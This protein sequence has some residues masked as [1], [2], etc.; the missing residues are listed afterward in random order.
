MYILHLLIWLCYL[1][2]LA[3]FWPLSRG[4]NNLNQYDT[5]ILGQS[6][7]AICYTR[8]QHSIQT[9]VI[10]TGLVHWDVSQTW[11][12]SW[13]CTLCTK[14]VNTV[15]QHSNILQLA[16][17]MTYLGT[18]PDNLNYCFEFFNFNFFIIIVLDLK[19]MNHV[20]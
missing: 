14:P 11:C 9:H 7:C 18:T 15:T 2:L 20:F 1:F 12:V 19:N 16:Y 13:S 17:P 6:T 3:L 4:Y 5:N 8:S 10:S